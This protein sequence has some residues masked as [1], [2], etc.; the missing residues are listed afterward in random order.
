M[1]FDPNEF[2]LDDQGQPQNGYVSDNDM[3]AQSLGLQTEE[4]QGDPNQYPVQTQQVTRRARA[5]ASVSVKLRKLAYY[6]AL[7]EMNFFETQDGLSAQVEAE[8]KDFIES[9]IIELDTGVPNQ[10]VQA[11]QFSEEDVKVLTAWAN[12]L[13]KKAQQGPTVAAPVATPVATNVPKVRTVRRPAPTVAQPLP[14][15][16]PRPAPSSSPNRQR[17]QAPQGQIQQPRRRTV[18][19]KVRGAA[20]PGVPQPKPMPQGEQMTRVTETKAQIEASQMMQ[21]VH[22]EG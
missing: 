10:P 7:M 9:K 20:T 12:T 4:Q 16:S 3:I 6:D 1:P 15:Q 17:P 22:K 13:K 8:V 11:T 19:G 2:S 18:A 14:A 21:H 5:R